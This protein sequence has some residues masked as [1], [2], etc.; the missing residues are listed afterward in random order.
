MAMASK[1]DRRLEQI[2]DWIREESGKTVT[3]I[4]VD[5]NLFT[6]DLMD[7][8]GFIQLVAFLEDE[9]DVLLDSGL[10]I[11][12]NFETPRRIAELVHRQLATAEIDPAFSAAEEG[13]SVS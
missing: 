1:A 4:D 5:T 11:P 10:L 6:A 13:G 12:A 9:Y 2:V 8:M 7:S 3:E